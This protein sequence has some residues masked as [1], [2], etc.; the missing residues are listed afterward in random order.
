MKLSLNWAQQYSNVDLA[1]GSSDQLIDA[2]GRQI[3]EVEDVQYWGSRYEGVV[4]ARIVTCHKHENADKLSVCLIDDGGVVED[5]T[6]D[7]AGHVQVVCGA[8]N[9]RDDMLV[10][11]LPPGS[12][13]PSTVT[14]DPF[15]LEA[16]E[17]RGIVSNGM[18]ASERE[19]GISDEHE[20][21]L[22]INSTEVGP[23]LAT[24]GT[25]FKKLFNLDDA[26]VE[27]ENKML[28]HRPDCFGILGLARE[29]AGIQGKAFVSPSWYTDT[30]QFASDNK[31]T[32]DADVQDG[33]LVPRFT[34]I[35]LDNVHVKPSP[36]WLQAGLTRVGI[37]PINNVVDITNF[38][39]HLTGQ[40]L[41]AY[42]AEK[43]KQRG[44]QYKL[45]A[46][47]AKEGDELTLLNGKSIKPEAPTIVI[48]TDTEV[49]GLGGVMGGSGTEVDET[50]TSVLLEC[51]TF[52]MYNIRRT[53]MKHGLFTDAVTR[54]TKGQSSLQNDRVAAYAVTL[55]R[56]L[57]NAE[58]AS[59]FVDVHQNLPQLATVNVTADFINDRLGTSLTADEIASLLT[60]VEFKVDFGN[61][62]RVTAPFWRTD[63]AIPEDI[64]E[65]VG[66]LYGYDKVPL[67]LPARNA[68]PAE[69]A[70][71]FALKSR[72][73]NL[74]AASGANEVLTYS[75]VHGKLIEQ[76]GQSL[77]KAYA[78]SNA[79]SPGLQYYRL[80]LTPSLLEKIHPNIKAG[81]DTFSLFELNTVHVK[82]TGLDDDGTPTETH[83]LALTFTATSKQ[84]EQFPGAAY[85]QSRKYLDHIAEN[86]GI[87]L[88]YK[89]LENLPDY[90]YAQP[91]A[92]SRSALVVEKITQTPLGIVGEYHEMAAKSLKLPECSSGFEISLDAIMSL[93]VGETNYRP[94]SRFPWSTQDISF[95]VSA[96]TTYQDLHD[97]IEAELGQQ[98]A[99]RGYFAELKP[100]DIYQ[101]ADNPTKKHIAFSL[102]VSHPDKTLT[103]D[104]V[105]SLLS[106]IADAAASA[107]KAER[108]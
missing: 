74:L 23:E 63:I 66:R 16:R 89:P 72:L 28:T 25:A 67:Q 18:L 44:G 4:V 94:L 84:A 64:V 81:Y 5:V 80:S 58:I 97:C 9:V 8:P 14:K 7:D 47:Q 27:I 48:A 61:T 79:L 32:V 104:E 98:K 19:L 11:W 78:L 93:N 71:I 43:V 52:D 70:T 77:E 108:L 105:N 69:Q 90:Q 86:L 68:R 88:A 29:L 12:T 106:S 1:E 31:I 24:P 85:Y 37:K 22:E 17:L 57:A 56:D 76:A 30:P 53:S 51:A 103:T 92:V 99:T 54:F 21:I 35:A 20:G 3:G 95:A 10:A 62:L 46:R 96:A 49:I 107:V 42:D 75:F 13:V 33:E 82:D 101:Q 15:V 36:T 2:I 73:R 83:A 102:H 50:T 39:M 41:H 100:I 55:L 34:A 91:F 45:V 26:V 6:R 40:P 38:V 59:N 65:E 60:N 87:S